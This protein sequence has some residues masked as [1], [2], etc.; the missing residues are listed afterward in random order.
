MSLSG[1]G[2]G[3]A[4]KRAYYPS[5]KLKSSSQDSFQATP[6]HPEHQFQGTQCP[7]LASVSTCTHMY[8][9]MHAF[10][11]NILKCHYETYHFVQWIYI[12]CFKLARWIFLAGT[13]FQFSIQLNPQLSRVVSSPASSW[14]HMVS[15]SSSLWAHIAKAWAK[16]RRSKQ[17]HLLRRLVLG[18]EGQTELALFNSYPVSGGGWYHMPWD[19]APTH[20]T[21]IDLTSF[22]LWWI[23]L[24]QIAKSQ[25]EAMLNM[26]V[27]LR[28]AHKSHR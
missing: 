20:L 28:E 5:R 9:Y 23:F 2:H 18:A 21:H 24:H 10:K 7:L 3:S 13:N 4:G 27:L 8:T 14:S 12:N 1:L 19:V 6:K 25:S 16:K 22:F 26:Q 15:F 17:G 11:K